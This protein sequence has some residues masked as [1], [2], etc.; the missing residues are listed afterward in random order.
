VEPENP[1]AMAK[2]ILEVLSLEENLW[3]QLSMRA[4]KR[5]QS[6][7]WS[8]ASLLFEEALFRSANN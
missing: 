8:D 4:F 3:Q 5:V 1:E 2:A 6:Y 7:T